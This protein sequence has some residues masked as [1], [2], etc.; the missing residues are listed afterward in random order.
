MSMATKL[1]W[2]LTYLEGVSLIKSHDP[3][4]TWSCEISWRTKT[5]YMSTTTMSMATKLDRVVTYCQAGPPTKS[6]GCLVIRSCEILLQTKTTIAP[7]P[8]CL[9]PPNSARW[10]LT[11]KGS[12]LFSHMTLNIWSCE[13]TR[14]INI[15]T[16]TM[17][18][19]I[20]LAWMVT[21]NEELPLIK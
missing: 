7:L 17:S 16:T 1:G 6:E 21:Y 9:W 5:H 13:V 18:M 10:W 4:I 15:S 12:F 3:L 19:V 20:R 8:E 14:Q 2:V 11:M